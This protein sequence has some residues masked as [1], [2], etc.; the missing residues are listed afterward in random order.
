M[1]D[2]RAR[3]GAAPAR[4]TGSSSA[5][6]GRSQRPQDDPTAGPALFAL[7]RSAIAARGGPVPDPQGAPAW[8]A[9][10]GAAFVTLTLDGRL[11]GCVGSIHPRRSLRDDIVANA[12]AAAFGDSRF[13]PL[14]A[15]ELPAVRIEVSLLSAL[16]PLPARSREDLLAAL[17]PGADG[18]VLGWRGHRGTFLPQVWEQLPDREDFVDHLLHKAGL[19]VFFWEPDMVAHR[20]GVTSWTEPRPVGERARL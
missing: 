13:R 6:A 7:A 19:P 2:L 5:P 14:A 16:E 10:P 12:R 15:S 4:S 3:V 18:L 17:R 20:F 1:T 9:E 11:R 8:L